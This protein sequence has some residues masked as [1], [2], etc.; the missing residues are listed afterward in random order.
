[1]IWFSR[2]LIPS[3]S[4]FYSLYVYVCVSSV[5]RLNF[6]ILLMRRG[7]GDAHTD[8]TAIVPLPLLRCLRTQNESFALLRFHFSLNICFS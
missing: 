2:A 7:R 1:M 5:K 4:G 8:E 3:K 6:C